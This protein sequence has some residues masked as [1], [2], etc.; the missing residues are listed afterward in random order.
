[1]YIAEK[2]DYYTYSHMIILE[3]PVARSMVLHGRNSKHKL[4]K[5]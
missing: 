5:L 2:Q 4:Q 3:V 1:M